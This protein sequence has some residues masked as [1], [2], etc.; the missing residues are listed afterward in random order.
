[1]R[2]FWFLLWLYWAAWLSFFSI[3]LGMFSALLIT[4]GT[5]LNKGAV[6]LSAEVWSALG[7]LVWFWFALSWSVSLLIGLLLVV[8]RLFY[9]CIDHHQLVFVLCLSQEEIHDL[10]VE[11]TIRLWRKWLISIIWAVAAQVVIIIVIEYLTGWGEG[12][13]SWFSIYWLYGFVLIAGAITLPMMDA[14]CK[15]VKVKQC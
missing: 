7:D 3:G 4:G 2:R 12:V 11:D 1:M 14:R 5:Y 8:K 15:M 10:R 9:R 13:L 6:T